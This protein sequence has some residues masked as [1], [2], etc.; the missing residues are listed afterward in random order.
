MDVNRG[1]ASRPA[2]G[3]VQGAHSRSRDPVSGRTSHEVE[4]SSV[5]DLDMAKALLGEG[6]EEAVAAWNRFRRGAERR[7]VLDH[8]AL[9][10]SN[11]TGADLRNCSFRYADFR[12]V[13]LLGARLDDSDLTGAD[14]SHARM[15][16]ARLHRTRLL[17]ANLT[18]A[19]LRW[20]DLQ[21]ADLRNT[22]LCDVALDPCDWGGADLSGAE[23]STATSAQISTSLA[24]LEARGDHPRKVFFGVLGL[25]IFSVLTALGAS[26]IDLVADRGSIRIPLL[27]TEVSLRGFFFVAP[28]SCCV[29]MLY[30]FAH[31]RQLEFAARALPAIL[32]DGALVT[33]KLSPWAQIVGPKNV[34]RKLTR[35]P[36]DEKPPEQGD[37]SGA[38]LAL[39]VEWLVPCSAL[40]LYILY[41]R[42]RQMHQVWMMGAVVGVVSVAN[43]FGWRFARGRVF[44]S[45]GALTLVAIAVAF[46]A[47]TGIGRLL[48]GPLHARNASLAAIIL[49]RVDL[50]RADLSYADLSRA[51]FRRVEL[52]EGSMW[53]ANVVGSASDD[54]H[55]HALRATRADLTR[56]Y[57]KRSGLEE[58][59]LQ[60]AV[61]KLAQ[62]HSVR[63]TNANLERVFAQQAVFETVDLRGASLE[64]ADLRDAVL[65]C[66]DL[67]GARLSSALLEGIRATDLACDEPPQTPDAD[68]LKPLRTHCQ[69]FE[70]LAPHCRQRLKRLER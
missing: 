29:V 5:S 69:R 22:R 32:P 39:V 9:A 1:I 48:S 16:V 35:M 52:D 2:D 33:D 46:A 13:A 70:A 18:S 49:D 8:I 57:F 12:R 23:L 63:F 25:C 62:F 30:V 27:E 60:E 50:E 41:F 43:L 40:I 6:G 31:L 37:Q 26:E 55:F 47:G 34:E 67:R 44:D 28:L 14:L 38:L 21:A 36:G 11:L 42:G 66:V 19:S 58:A 20:A 4:A 68:P 7:L 56:A 53:E 54:S 51:Q 65:T 10:G 61:F 15:E 3:E 64:R 24:Q 45:G 59:V 17:S